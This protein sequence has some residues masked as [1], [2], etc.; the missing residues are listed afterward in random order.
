MPGFELINKKQELKEIK[1]IFD[2]GGV[3]F[4]QGFETIRDQSYKVEE[5][6]NKFKEKFKS[7]FSLAV[8]SGT[9]H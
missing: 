2:S 9:A 3:L 6:E 7:K 5:F 1:K 8:S 4:R